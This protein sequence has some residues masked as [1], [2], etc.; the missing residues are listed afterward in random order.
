MAKMPKSDAPA[1][2][3]ELTF[4]AALG[5]LE[6][7]VEAMEG[8]QMPLEQMLARYE[9]GMKLAALCARKLAEAELKVQQL[10]KAAEGQF[11]L[12]PF[13]PGEPVDEADST[14]A[15]PPET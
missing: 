5:R 6:S 2:S 10:E 1:A 12:R 15:G 8:G 11:R 3:E 7:I 9:E 13:G 4:E 14:E